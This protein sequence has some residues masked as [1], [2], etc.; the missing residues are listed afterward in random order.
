M[1]RALIIAI[2]VVAL[3]GF[4]F[5]FRRGEVI[6]IEEK[7]QLSLAEMLSGEEEG[8]A[9]AFDV[10][11]FTF[12]Q[13]HG[14]HPDFKTEWWYYTGNLATP[15]GRAFG[16]QFTL[17]RVALSSAPAKRESAWATNH[18][19]MAHLA[20]T[21]VQ[22]GKFFAFERFARGTMGLAG[23]ASDPLR[24]W[25]EDWRVEETDPGK[26]TGIPIMH[27]EA[28]EENLGVDL[29]LNSVKPIILQG[30]RGLSRKG[31]N[32]GNASYYYS[33]TRLEAKGKIRFLDREHEVTGWAWMDREWSTSA[34]EEGQVGWD[35]FALQLD[36]GE[37]L[38]FYRMRRADGSDDLH[39]HGCWVNGSGRSF[40]IERNDVI[41]ET[42]DHWKNRDG[43]KY[44]SLWQF[45]VPVRDTVLRI[46]PLVADQELRLRLHYWEGAVSVEGTI[47]DRKVSGR[48]Y[49]EL[50]GYADKPLWR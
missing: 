42:L 3:A 26:F 1:V 15:S 37:D 46:E 18:V 6:H 17:F 43:E 13:D 4:Y 11:E 45:S 39:S 7:P 28:S 20:L 22:A 44:P 10:R 27:L 48:G 23:A 2:L 35:W 29:I 50:T 30:D 5:Y 41:I 19:Y 32:P 16:F 47:A 38:M 12:P 49:V 25:L 31:R 34:L 21:D 33:L 14:P 9:Q 36:N 24:L 40:P 8:F